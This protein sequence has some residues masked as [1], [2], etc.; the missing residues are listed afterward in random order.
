MTVGEY[1]V[2]ITDCGKSEVRKLRT[3]RLQKLLRS[4]CM[5][6]AIRAGANGSIKI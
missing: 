5:S 3:L 6:Y 1:I 2:M 4:N